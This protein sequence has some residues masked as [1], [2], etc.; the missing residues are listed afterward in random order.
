MNKYKHTL[1]KFFLRIFIVGLNFQINTCNVELLILKLQLNFFIP[2]VLRTF[3]E[4]FQICERCK[5][6]KFW[7]INEQLKEC[8]NCM[9]IEIY[10]GKFIFLVYNVLYTTLETSMNGCI[11]LKRFNEALSF[12]T[13]T[14]FDENMSYFPWSI[15]T[16]HKPI[17]TAF[18]LQKIINFTT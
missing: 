17:T 3:N 8:L 15:T 4:T 7:N 16:T 10:R 18:Y 12:K 6:P 9:K 5:V 14:L 13:V 11:S 2:W 1:C